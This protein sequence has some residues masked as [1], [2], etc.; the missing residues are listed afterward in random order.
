MAIR[1]VR[2]FDAGSAF[3]SAQLETQH[4]NRVVVESP[5][6][7]GVMSR[8]SQKIIQDLITREFVSHFDVF[9]HTL[10]SA[11]SKVSTLS[12]IL[13]DKFSPVRKLRDFTEIQPKDSHQK[14]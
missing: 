3:Y 1:R 2:R 4:S 8:L 6:L 9:A 13:N 14:N 5:T 10:L 11:S 12:L 7:H